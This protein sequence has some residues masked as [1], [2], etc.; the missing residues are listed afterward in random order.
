MARKVPPFDNPGILAK[1]V[2]D[3][4]QGK[5]TYMAPYFWSLSEAVG[6]VSGETGYWVVFTPSRY[7]DGVDMHVPLDDWTI[8][9]TFVSQAEVNKIIRF[10]AMH[11]PE[12]QR[13]ALPR[14]EPER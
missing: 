13:R 9:G 1:V 6:R 8:N 10:H 5:V 12:H 7:K 11:E 3:W 2:T 14:E 4:A